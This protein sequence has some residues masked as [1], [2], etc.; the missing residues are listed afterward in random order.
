MQQAAHLVPLQLRHGQQILHTS[1]QIKKC[2]DS[3]GLWQPTWCRCSCATGRVGYRMSR[4]STLG[5]SMANAANGET[6]VRSGYKL[7][8]DS[9]EFST[10]T[11]GESMANAAR[12]AG[13]TSI[14]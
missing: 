4:T 1:H 3:E 9:A 11:L 14:S 8:C 5:E 2:S 10:R 12:K 7:K 6:R 13:D